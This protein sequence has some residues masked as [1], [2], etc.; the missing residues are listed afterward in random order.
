MGEF[1]MGHLD[2]TLERA[3]ALRKA[4]LARYGTTMRWLTVEHGLTEI[5]RF[6]EFVHPANLDD[7]L[8][9]ENRTTAQRALDGVNLPASILTNA[10]REHADRVLNWLG[11]DSRFEH[12][13]DIRFNRMKGKPH[14]AAYEV[15]L[16]KTGA[17]PD[18][19]LFADDVLEY[20]LPF[21]DIGG[22][23]VQVGTEPT[24]EPGVGSMRSIAD[25]ADVVS[26]G[27]RG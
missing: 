5:E 10:P 26:R 24:N 21:R 12:V 11:L 23:V 13:F 20:L 8:T 22:H 18:E 2:V 3:S 1:V 25:L 19:T 15:A 16:E 14:R 17:K 4:G 7:F 27:R 6:I 9:D